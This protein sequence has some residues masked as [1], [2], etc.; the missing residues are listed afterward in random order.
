MLIKTT[1]QKK[2]KKSQKKYL[3]KGCKCGIIRMYQRGNK[4]YFERA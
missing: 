1:K 2:I 4:K 3:T